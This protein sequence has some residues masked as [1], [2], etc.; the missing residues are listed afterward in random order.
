MTGSLCYPSSLPSSTK[1]GTYG[2][3]QEL[4]QALTGRVRQLEAEQDVLHEKIEQSVST[5]SRSIRK[6]VRPLLLLL[7]SWLLFVTNSFRP[8]LKVAEMRE[9]M[10]HKFS[11][12]LAE[13]KRLQM[14]ITQ[15]K[16]E[17][18]SQTKRDLQ[19]SPKMFRL[20]RHFVLPAS[21]EIPL[22]PLPPP[23]PTAR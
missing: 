22:T 18:R 10:E 12:Q 9:E 15:L 5:S 14:H 6:E 7:L 8:V 11:L 19:A 17:N 20:P 2:R 13:N 23:F 4:I 1:N 21:I 16:D 3:L